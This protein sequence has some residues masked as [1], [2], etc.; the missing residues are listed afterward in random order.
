MFWQGL[1]GDE[2]SADEEPDSFVS[3]KLEKLTLEQIREFTRVLSQDRKKLNQRL[4]AIHKEIDL[5]SAKLD[6]LKIVGADVKETLERLNQLSDMGQTMSFEL[7]KLNEKL[8]V[9]RRR[10][11]FLKKGIA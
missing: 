11:D 1:V 9:A 4:E 2:E 7:S 3:G 6:S 8:K 10:E 5:N